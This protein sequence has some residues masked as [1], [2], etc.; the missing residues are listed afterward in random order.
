MCWEENAA[1]IACK[2]TK[3]DQALKEI[4]DEKLTKKKVWK[5]SEKGGTGVKKDGAADE[6]WAIKAAAW[7]DET[8]TAIAATANSN[9]AVS[10][11][12]KGTDVED[13]Y[14]YTTILQSKNQKLMLMISDS[15]PNIVCCVNGPI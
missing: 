5:W 1:G 12:Q 15:F 14:R 3:L 11:S 8:I 7:Y 4:I 13:D 10:A 6:H 9:T 2:E